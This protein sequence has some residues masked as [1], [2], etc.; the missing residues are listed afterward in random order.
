MIGSWA[1]KL[2][3]AKKK[4]DRLK[5]DMAIASEFYKVDGEN[6]IL[7]TQIG[8]MDQ[9]QTTLVENEIKGLREGLKKSLP[10]IAQARRE[11]GAKQMTSYVESVKCRALPQSK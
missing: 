6:K 4:N 9:V 3:R 1:E 11:S 5:A 2:R 10:Q 7:E 8:M